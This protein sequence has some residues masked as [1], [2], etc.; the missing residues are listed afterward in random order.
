MQP[1]NEEE[2]YK[3]NKQLLSELTNYIETHRDVRFIQALW[4]LN[5]INAQV[6]KQT[7]T[8]LIEDRFYEEPNE[9]LRRVKDFYRGNDNDDSNERK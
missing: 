3:Y 8:L 7:A 9:T 4:A 5:I 2:R 1:L 6:D